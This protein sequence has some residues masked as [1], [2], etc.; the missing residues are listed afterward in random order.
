MSRRKLTIE[1]HRKLAGHLGFI[2]QE[3][4]E[5]HQLIRGCGLTGRVAG[6]LH[7]AQQKLNQVKSELEET[8]FRDHRGAPDATTDLYYGRRE[9]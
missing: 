4:S 5:V 8:L 6:K 2:R 7:G 3:M 9:G 1:E